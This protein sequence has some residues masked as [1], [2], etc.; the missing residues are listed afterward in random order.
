[1]GALEKCQFLQPIHLHLTIEA[2]FKICVDQCDPIFY[3]NV[4]PRTVPISI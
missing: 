3:E 1:M 4:F 2:Q